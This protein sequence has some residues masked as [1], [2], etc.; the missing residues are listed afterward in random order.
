M[1]STISIQF[2]LPAGLL[3]SLCYVESK[4]NTEAVHYFDGDANS[5]GVC[6][7]KLA[8]AQYLGFEGDEEELM[9]PRVNIYYAA[10]YLSRQR[11]RYKGSIEK[12]IIAYNIGHAG[13]L[14]RT[15]YSDRVIK[16]WREYADNK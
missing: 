7:I 12:A 8:T 14:T 11:V 3:S 13:S 16:Q 9:Q 10:A 4:H 5:Y 15:S 2:G 1:F 6:Q